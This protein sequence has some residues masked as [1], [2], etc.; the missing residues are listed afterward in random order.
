MSIEK[1]KNQKEHAKGINDAEI[2]SILPYLKNPEE[3][4]PAIENN[5]VPE[6]NLSDLIE[7]MELSTD[8]IAGTLIARHLYNLDLLPDFKSKVLYNELAMRINAHVELL[9][10]L[11]DKIEE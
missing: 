7:L 1:N 8:D 11:S 10:Q 3:E 9:N 5:P 6:T 4:E 2:I